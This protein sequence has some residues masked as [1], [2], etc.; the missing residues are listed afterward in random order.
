MFYN[1]KTEINKPVKLIILNEKNINS[2]SSFWDYK[3]LPYKYSRILNEIRYER[4]VG[5]I[6]IEII[7]QGALVR[8][9]NNYDMSMLSDTYRIDTKLTTVIVVQEENKDNLTY[10]TLVRFSR[11]K[12]YNS[13][14]NQDIKKVIKQ[15]LQ[16][17]DSVYSNIEILKKWE[18]EQIISLQ[19][20]NMLLTCTVMFNKLRMKIPLCEFI[21]TVNYVLSGGI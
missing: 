10:D 13:T 4:F 16:I 20:T 3:Y 19:Y 6:V 1:L 8:E 7:P 12:C 5:D 9:L 14:S 17:M 18:D 15:E 2:S 11:E 21:D